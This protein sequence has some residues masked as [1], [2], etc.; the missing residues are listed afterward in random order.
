MR[1]IAVFPS[2]YFDCKITDPML[3]EEYDSCRETGLFETVLFNYEK[4]FCNGRLSLSFSPDTET[5]AV[6]RGWM[7]KPEQYKDFYV[8]LLSKNIRLITSPDQ[9]ALMHVF[10]NIHPFFGSDSPE[11]MLFPEGTSVDLAKI[12]Q[13]FKRFMVKDYVKSV[14][15][16]D[17]PVYFDS[18]VDEKTFAEWMHTFYDYRGDLF[19]GGICVKEYVDL[20][21]YDGH[22]NEHRVFYAGHDVISVWK[23]GGQS[24]LT[25]NPPRRLIEQYRD[26]NSPFYTIDYAELANGEWKILEAGDGSVSGL[27]DGQNVVSFFRALYFALWDK[28]GYEDPD[29]MPGHQQKI[30]VNGMEKLVLSQFPEQARD[31]DLAYGTDGN[32]LGHV[33]AY[34]AISQPM[35]SLCHTDQAQFELYCDLLE[36]LWMD[37]DE[38]ILDILNVTILEDL[39]EDS[40]VWKRFKEYI[41]DAFKRY[42]GVL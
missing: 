39:S 2:D 8:R 33:F 41:G 29:V 42:I 17:F 9:Y 31:I 4:W 3:Q 13:K 7:M 22:A 34:H 28:S 32:I 36:R 1:P 30:D 10:P 15:G 26:L 11:I 20:K 12:R 38:S 35:M 5:A 19:T 14:K 6:Y 18:D 24:T 21:K 40:V 23:N 25:P 16:T 27:S 37:G